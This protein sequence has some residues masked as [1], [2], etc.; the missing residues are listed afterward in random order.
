MNDKDIR[1]ELKK[2]LVKQ[3]KKTK[4]TLILDELAIKHGEARIDIVVVNNQIHGYEI[5][6]DSD[7]L[8]RLP[9]QIEAYNS[10]FNRVTLIVGYKHAYEALRMVPT[11]WGVKLAEM[12]ESTGNIV[13]T[14]A[15]PSCN[16]PKVDI[17][18]VL[19]LLWRNEALSILEELGIEKGVRSKTR[20][21]IYRRLVESGNHEYL[22]FMIRQ[23]LKYRKNW[24]VDAQ[25]M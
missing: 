18:E 25:R 20:T 8:K 21:E 12:E 15:R 3:H 7:S 22:Y 23:L 10:V 11:W 4:D 24:R 6:S 5:K 13:F 14:E 17:N 1:L 2:R 19:S 16:N 9:D